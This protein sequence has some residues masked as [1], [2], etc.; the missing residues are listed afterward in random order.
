MSK[1]IRNFHISTDSN[2]EYASVFVDF[3]VY[4]DGEKKDGVRVTYNTHSDEVQ[5]ER[6]QRSAVK[7]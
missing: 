3:D 5:V 4:V 2:G 6:L 1:S 7:A